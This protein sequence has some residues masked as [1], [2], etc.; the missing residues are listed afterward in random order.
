MGEI[1]VRF[2]A[3]ARQAAG[4]LETTLPCEAGSITEEALWKLLLA[5]FPALVTL[6]RSVRLARN[7]EYVGADATFSAGD[8]VAL[9]PPVSGG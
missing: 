6:R 9:I 4:C 8:E 1:T 2:F 5:E 3:S 7:H